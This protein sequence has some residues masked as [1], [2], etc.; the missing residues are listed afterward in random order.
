MSIVGG[1]R[2]FGNGRLVIS[3]AIRG[4]SSTNFSWAKKQTKSS[5]TAR[6]DARKLRLQKM[7]AKRLE[8]RKSPSLNPLYMDISTALR[9][10][11][12]AEVGRPLQEC[13]LTLQ[14]LVVNEQG[15]KPISGSVMLPRPIQEARILV[16]VEEEEVQQRVL[17]AG[18]RTVGGEELIEKIAKNEIPLNYNQCF[19]TPEMALKLSSIARI[20]GPKGLMP[21]VKRGSVT[22]DIELK[23]TEV[24]GTLP[25][26]QRSQI[27]ALPVGKC[28]FSDEDI[29]K[30]IMA[31]SQEVKKS[32]V[33][34]STKRPALIGQT[35]LSSPHGP[36]IVIDF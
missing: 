31:I 17:R 1:V 15:A 27:L 32:A 7:A 24:L 22:K 16:F 2:S 10:L 13:T 6:A 11:R 35:V 3:Q 26:R 25:F 18:A 20:L 30:N 33:A 34:V 36:G 5:S 23:M 4:F 19:A 28:S 29:I 21:N 8:A 14:M 12:A 9:Y